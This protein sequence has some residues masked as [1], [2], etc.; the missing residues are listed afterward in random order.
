MFHVLQPLPERENMQYITRPGGR[1]SFQSF[2]LQ[3]QNSFP[4]ENAETDNPNLVGSRR[5]A[6][7]NGNRRHYLVYSEDSDTDADLEVDLERQSRRSR[8]TTRANHSARRLSGPSCLNF[9]WAFL[10][11]IRC[12][13]KMIVL[14]AVIIYFKAATNAKYDS[15]GWIKT[16]RLGYKQWAFCNSRGMTYSVLEDQWNP[17]SSVETAIVVALNKDGTLDSLPCMDSDT[18]DKLAVLLDYHSGSWDFRDFALEGTLQ[19]QISNTGVAR[20]YFPSS[21]GIAMCAYIAAFLTLALDTLPR[22]RVPYLSQREKV[23]VGRVNYIVCG[24]LCI[25]LAASS[26][27]F[28]LLF[29]EDCNFAFE[30]FVSNTH[31]DSYKANE[32]QFCALLPLL[33]VS[34]TSI[35][36]PREPYVRMYRDIVVTLCIVLIFGILIKPDPSEDRPRGIAAV[37]PRVVLEYILGERAQRLYRP[38]RILPGSFLQ[39][40]RDHPAFR[41]GMG[42]R[43]LYGRRRTG[44][45][46]SSDA[47][48]NVDGTSLGSANIT[49]EFLR[50]YS[51]VAS[52]NKMTKDWKIVE[53]PAPEA[54]AEEHER[55]CTICLELLFSKFGDKEEVDNMKEEINQQ[56]KSKIRE[57]PTS[58]GRVPGTNSAGLGDDSAELVFALP[59]GHKYHKPCILEWTFKNTTC[60]DC[61]ANLDGITSISSE[62][63]TAVSANEPSASLA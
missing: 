63:P 27:N 25:L 36:S 52:R 44:A 48:S 1:V 61:R 56:I 22:A 24:V 8:S 2:A 38:R 51:M 43:Q 19:D 9:I 45:N 11:F 42:I 26:V 23:N 62:A 57:K 31:S 37:V 35:I 33:G 6:D 4:D 20:D 40:L 58:K 28:S 41:T 53:R 21:T 59:C 49:N 14:V 32:K 30:L 10:Y 47:L 16:R 50:R 54:P 12:H 34:I 7:E 60:P 13:L 5:A 39:T 17:P 18:L 46:G 55:C 15:E 3:R 29:E